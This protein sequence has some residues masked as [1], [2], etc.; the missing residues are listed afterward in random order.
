MTKLSCA[1]MVASLVVLTIAPVLST[2]GHATGSVVTVPPPQVA[3]YWVSVSRQPGGTL[4]FDGYA[5]DEA[6][7]ATFSQADGA[8]TSWLKLGSGAP[9]LYD[10]ATAFGLA[11]LNRLSEGRFA[12]RGTVLS[13]SGVANTQADFIDLR[14]NLRTAVPQGTIL[15]MAEISAPRIERYTFS[16]R[17]NSGGGL[18]LSG[19]VPS[20]EV[21]NTLI[22]LAGAGTTSA[23]R[24]GSGEPVDFVSVLDHALPL[25]SRLADGEMRL[26]RG[27][28]LLSGTPKSA[29]DADSIRETLAEHRLIEHGW[30]L[31]L[32]APA[33]MPQPA[34]RPVVETSAEPRP[35]RE[36]IVAETLV[37]VAQ[38]AAAAPDAAA[39]DQCRAV[40]DE[41]SDQNAILF[42]SGAAVLLEGASD[43]IGAMADALARCPD[44][45]VEV[46]GH[47]DSDGDAG[48][49]LALSVARAEAVVSVLINLGIA[50]D[51][52]YAVGYGES[53]PVADNGSPA[54][55]ALNRRIVVSLRVPN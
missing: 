50:P 53:Q 31:A 11:T 23:L 26:D 32:A 14:Q 54:G 28:W 52:L 9:S 47:T 13:V 41:L 16:A 38:V 55:K 48:A 8:D 10:A 7:R 4:V 34:V 24:Y 17:L 29:A 15:A 49:N 46:A 51:R 12:L 18:A 30:S 25:M 44:A 40:L 1:R 27:Q 36:P 2:P 22:D 37:G 43:I 19:Y 6:T 21:E 39:L 42:R 35:D 33:P 5:P 20:P 3:D 45:S